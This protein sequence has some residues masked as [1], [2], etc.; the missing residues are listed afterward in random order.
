MLGQTVGI[1]IEALVTSAVI[2]KYL[3]GS[4]RQWLIQ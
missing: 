2:E 1:D 4:L 3:W